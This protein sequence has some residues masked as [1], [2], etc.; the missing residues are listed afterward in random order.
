M[1]NPKIC[2]KPQRTSNSQSNL[3]KNMA[4]AIMLPDFPLYYKTIV[5]RIVWNWQKNKHRSMEQNKEPRNTPYLWLINLQQKPQEYT[6]GN[7]QSL[8]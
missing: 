4:E 7:G 5:I 3:K 2:I 1:N 8:Q 6:M